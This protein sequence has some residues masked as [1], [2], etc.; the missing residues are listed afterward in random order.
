M[1]SKN[2]IVCKLTDIM[3]DRFP[4]KR[5]TNRTYKN[6]GTPE[7]W[8]ELARDNWDLLQ[9]VYDDLIDIW[10]LDDRISDGYTRSMFYPLFV[11]GDP[12]SDLCK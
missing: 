7:E 4:G 5:I 3:Y 8:L 1:S 9:E 11:G 6:I 2:D 10:D 12:C